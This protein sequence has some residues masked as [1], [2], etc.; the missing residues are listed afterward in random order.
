MAIRGSPSVTDA[1]FFAEYPFLPGAEALAGELADSMRT[2]LESPTLERARELGRARVRAA[3]DDP[4]GSVGIED[5]DRA[6][7]GERFLSFQYARILLGATKS[8]APLRRHR[9]T[10]NRLPRQRA[11]QAQGPGLAAAAVVAVRRGPS[12]LPGSSS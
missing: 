2:L 11:N 6:D 12:S 4:L 7:P 3:V 5:L 8:A 10:R 9:L 1:G